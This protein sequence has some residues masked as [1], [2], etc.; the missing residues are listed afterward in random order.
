MSGAAFAL[1]RRAFDR[2]VG[3][4]ASD[5]AKQACIDGWLRDAE[6]FLADEQD[7]ADAQML[8]DYYIDEIM[9]SPAKK[10]ELCGS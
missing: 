10:A 3:C 4:A 6:Q 8:L 7:R 9:R 2:L 1:Y 5:A